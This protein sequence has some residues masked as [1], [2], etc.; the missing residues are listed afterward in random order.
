M[1]GSR[2]RSVHSDKDESTHAVS[3]ADLKFRRAADEVVWR[4]VARH[5]CDD[6]KRAGAH[7]WRQWQWGGWALVVSLAELVDFYTN[8][9]HSWVIWLVMVTWLMANWH[10]FCIFCLDTNIFILCFRKQGWSTLLC[11]DWHVSISRLL[12]SINVLGLMDLL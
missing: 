7:G 5:N 8:L 6:W 12:I 1:E 4:H 3:M 10:L 9:P 11:N 2:D